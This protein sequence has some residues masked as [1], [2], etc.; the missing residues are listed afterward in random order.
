MV[1]SHPSEFK[2]GT[3]YQFPIF[4]SGEFMGT[5]PFQDPLIGITGKI[6]WGIGIVSPF[7]GSLAAPR[8]TPS[9]HFCAKM[10]R[11]AR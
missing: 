10:D 3:Q 11:Y 2:W 5:I 4:I 1:A 9:P 8:H 7:F 6:K